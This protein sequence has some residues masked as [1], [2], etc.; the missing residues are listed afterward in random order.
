MQSS[1]T[2]DIVAKKYR[3][4]CM[5]ELGAL[6]PGNVHI[7][8][9]GHGMVVEDFLKSADAS[10][11]PISKPDFCVGERIFQSVSA[12]WDAVSCNT[13]LGIVLLAAPLIQTVFLHHELSQSAL[14]QTLQQ[15]TIE[16]AKFA[17]QAIQLA[18]PAGLGEVAEHD[19]QNNPQ[20]TLLKA[21]QAAA[22]RDLI[23]QQYANGFADVFAGVERY[24]EYLAKWERPAW[25]LTAVYLGFLAT[26][27]DSHI[28]RKYGQDKAKDIQQQAQQHYAAYTKL[29]NPKLYQASLLSWDQTLKKQGI[30]P[31]TSADLAVATIL[32]NSLMDI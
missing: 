18:S 10:M 24:L 7:F 28:A 15:L 13:N 14:K 21:M 12:T 1:I 5:A 27:E 22:N 11:V 31:G 9:D 4:A 17:F 8:A 29:E 19:V 20:V 32:A 2:Q 16:D 25:A 6:K 23:A 26:F 30:N 3:E